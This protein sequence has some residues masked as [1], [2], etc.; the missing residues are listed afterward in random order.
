[1]NNVVVVGGDHYNTLWLVRSLGMGGFNVTVVI[2]NSCSPKSF[3]CKS[4][5]CKDSY[6]VNDFGEMIHQLYQLSFSYKVPVFTNGDAVAEAL[7]EFYDSLSQKY[8]L[9]HC[10]HAFFGPKGWYKYTL[11][12]IR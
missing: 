4:R 1:M 11:F 12:F 8:I 3:V 5:Y 9:H 2:I 10:N 6:I 7:D